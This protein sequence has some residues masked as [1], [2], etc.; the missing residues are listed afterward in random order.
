M[1]PRSVR[2]LQGWTWIVEGFKLFL[3]APA[4]WIVITLCFSLLWIMSLVIPF[5]GPVIFNLFSLVFLGGILIG[6]RDL[7][8]GKPLTLSH[9]FI[10]FK[11]NVAALVSVGG[12]YLAGTII[13]IGITLATVGHEA[14]TLF[15]TNKS[16]DTQAALN[17]VSEMGR[18]L[19][20]A[21]LLYMPL[22]MA[23]W[24]AP[25][26]I[27]F[28]Q[29]SVTQALIRSFSAC[30]INPLPFTIYGF[31]LMGLWVL[32][33]IPFLLGLLVVLP[34]AFCTVYVSYKDVFADELIEVLP[35][36]T[37]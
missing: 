5:L 24:F 11:T 33:S 2:P 15:Q 4:M 8:Q 31:A 17:V 36:E 3:L 21:L 1:K 23:I 16:M 34:L 37:P 14:F 27:I 22:M 20:V 9:L 10:G 25:A 28:N 6:C 26:L 19:L 29:L 30:L 13:I 18:S 12:V 32:G 7:E 35:P